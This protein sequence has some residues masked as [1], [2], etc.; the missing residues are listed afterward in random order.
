ME[1]FILGL[2][3]WLKDIN[4]GMII[5]F[6]GMGLLFFWV[7]VIGWVVADS[8]GRY[9]R[10]WMRIL[11]ISVVILVPLFGLL[12]YFIIRPRSTADEEEMLELER[13]YL[14]FEAAGLGDCPSCGCELLPNYV[15]C[16]RCGRELRKKCPSCDIYLEQD[17]YVC[18]FCGKRRG[19]TVLED[20]EKVFVKDE[21]IAKKE[22]I[23]SVDV[24]I[25]KELENADD[26]LPEEMPLREEKNVEQTEEVEETDDMNDKEV[27]KEE[28]EVEEVIPEKT[29]KLRK[30]IRETARSIKNNI[31]VKQK[32]VFAGVDG[33]VKY[34]GSRPLTLINRMRAKRTPSAEFSE[35][36]PSEEEKTA[37]QDQKQRSR[38]SKKKKQRKQ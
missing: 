27:S 9:E 19:V 2:L 33:F 7:V 12:I 32:K 13:R 11:A 26:A 36:M 8:R 38:V 16:P 18:P 25:R 31:S 30:S 35:E 21:Q 22:G 37:K 1:D 29:R 5:Q 15:F 4:F 10:N 3:D 24:S 17:W 23:E 28:S 20:E 6:L 14:R 34:I